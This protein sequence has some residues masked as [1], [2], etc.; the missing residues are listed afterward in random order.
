VSVT[1]R[2]DEA[3]NVVTAISEIA[4]G[5]MCD[6]VV[7]GQAIP[8]GHKMA[9]KPVKVGEAVVK[10]A[11]VIGRAHLDIAPGDHVHTH[12]LNFSAVDQD[13]EF[14]TD[15]RLVTPATS[16]DTFMGYRRDG[17]KVGTRNYV[18]IITS[19]NCSATAARMI[20]DHFTPAVMA[21]YPNVDGVAAFVHG[22]GCGMAGDGEGFEALQRVMWGYAR[23]P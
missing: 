23:H 7:S 1:V 9:V 14:G 18:A 20:A 17:G 22:T 3:D 6:G 21:D 15:L 12:N 5:V 16:Q 4:A 10:Y 13:Y 2:L 8:R 19:V 11:Q